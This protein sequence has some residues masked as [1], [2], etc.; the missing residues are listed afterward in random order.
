MT[1]A[2]D[3]ALPRVLFLEANEDGT[4]GGSHRILEDLVLHLDRGLV[5]PVV[6]FHERNRYVDR[7]AAA[8]VE[9]HLFDEQRRREREAHLSGRPWRK[10]A[11]M[12]DAV[13]ARHA[14]LR[15]HRIAMLHLNNSPGVGIDDWVPAARLARLPVLAMA[16]G[17]ARGTDGWLRQRMFSSLDVVFP[18]SRFMEDAMRRHGYDG[19]RNL[20]AYPGIDVE[21]ERSRATRDRAAVR[22]EFGVRDD[23]ALV[24][25]T[26]N[27][28][29]WKGQHVLVEAVRRLEPSVRRSCRVLLVGAES[30]HHAAYAASV[31]DRRRRTWRHGSP[32]G[33]ANRRAGPPARRRHCGPR[34]RSP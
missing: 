24:V 12:A 2:G 1:R 29:E 15:R 19:D 30:S 4:V 34:V 14:F 7:F 22:A 20:L 3:A 17:D 32:D 28:R 18:C 5:E 21:A 26:G 13:R 10:V 8:G 23:Q 11:A 9:V 25:M 27:I 6:V 16:V 31:R 33:D